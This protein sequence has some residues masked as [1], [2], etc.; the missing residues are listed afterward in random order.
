MGS[1]SSGRWRIF[2]ESFTNFAMNFIVALF[3]QQALGFN[4]AYAGEIMLPAACIWGLTSLG[5][6][7]LADRIEG[8]WLIVLGSLS[9]AIVLALFLRVTPWSTAWAVAWLL[10]L[11]SLTRGFHPVAHSH[12]HHGHPARSSGAVGRWHAR[13][14][15]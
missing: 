1:S 10:I 5:T 11:R 14:A 7:R 13:P 12:H 6:G 15:Q 8:R 2:V 4:A 9:Q 3:L